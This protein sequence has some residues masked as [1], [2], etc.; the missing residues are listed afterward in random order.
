MD[1][2][3]KADHLVRDFLLRRK[4]RRVSVPRLAQNRVLSMDADSVHISWFEVATAVNGAVDDP[5]LYRKPGG[6]LQNSSNTEQWL[7]CVSNR[8]RENVAGYT[9]ATL[10]PSRKAKA[11][12]HLIYRCMLHLVLLSN[13]FCSLCYPQQSVFLP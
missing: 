2:D 10:R 3:T 1:L 4:E 13:L 8:L 6:M 9:T 5:F 7:K 12:K 11:V